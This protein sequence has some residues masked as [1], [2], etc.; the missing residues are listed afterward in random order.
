MPYDKKKS[1]QPSLTFDPYGQAGPLE[2]EPPPFDHESLRSLAARLK[3]DS[4]GSSPW[5]NYSPPP[6]IYEELTED[7][8]Y[9]V[10]KKG[11]NTFREF[12]TYFS[13]ALL[14][15][16]ISCGVVFYLLRAYSSDR[17]DRSVT[18]LRA[19]PAKEQTGSGSPADQRGSVLRGD[20]RAE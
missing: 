18:A 16:T 20:R 11:G 9:P 2:A 6:N 4:S 12:W 19:L 7:G 15:A 13:V 10:E 8:R 14:T 3:F 17:S 5:S 1:S